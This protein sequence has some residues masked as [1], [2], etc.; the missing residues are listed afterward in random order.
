MRM[1]ILRLLI[2]SFLLIPSASTEAL[3]QD[4]P[5]ISDGIQERGISLT[6]KVKEIEYHRRSPIIVQYSVTNRR[7]QNVYLVTEKVTPG[8]KPEAKEVFLNLAI[9]GINYHTFAL[10]K[11]VKIKPDGSYEGEAQLPVGM[12]KDL[13]AT[14]KWLLYLTVGYLDEQDLVALRQMGAPGSLAEGFEQRQ[15][16][17]MAGPVRLDLFE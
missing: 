10:S 4:Q 1:R 16:L 15:K 11:M 6:F 8:T 12:D 7:K 5:I 2:V 14:G 13:S 9:F 17:L 3:A